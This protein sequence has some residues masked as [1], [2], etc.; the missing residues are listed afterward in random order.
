MIIFLIDPVKPVGYSL[1]MPKVAI[2]VSS[3]I[4][5]AEKALAKKLAKYDALHAEILAIQDAIARVKAATDG[6]K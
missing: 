6:A 5:R 4:A 3:A 1:V 2:D